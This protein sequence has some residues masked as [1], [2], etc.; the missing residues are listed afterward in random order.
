MHFAHCCTVGIINC[1]VINLL[2]LFSKNRTSNSIRYSV[3][4][5]AIRIPFIRIQDKQNE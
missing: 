2:K 3:P 4:S 5:I 1:N